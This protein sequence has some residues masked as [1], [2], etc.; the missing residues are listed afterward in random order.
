MAGILLACKA[1]T[2]WTMYILH[3]QGV[4]IFSVSLMIFNFKAESDMHKGGKKIHSF[5]NWQENV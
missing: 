4:K 2:S 3:F 1:G 5:Q